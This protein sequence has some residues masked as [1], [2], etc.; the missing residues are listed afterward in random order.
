[1]AGVGDLPSS[2]Y[3]THQRARLTGHARKGALG[4]ASPPRS[5]SLS[6]N[7]V[8]VG[9]G[10]GVLV[11]PAREEG[12]RLEVVRAGRLLDWGGVRTDT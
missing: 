2:G 6:I 11:Q 9:Q 5:G 3:S 12:S 10:D 4:G 1:V 7:F 8:D